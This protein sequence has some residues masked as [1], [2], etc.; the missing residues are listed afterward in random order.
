MQ[1]RTISKKDVYSPNLNYKNSFKKIKEFEDYIKKDDKFIRTFFIKSLTG[2]YVKTNLD[3]ELRLVGG[4][5]KTSVSFWILSEKKATDMVSMSE[6]GNQLVLSDGEDEKF[7]SAKRQTKAELEVEKSN[8][9]LRKIHEG[10]TH[11]V[12]IEYLV[13]TYADSLEELEDLSSIIEA[14]ADTY[15]LFL[16]TGIWQQKDMLLASVGLRK[17]MKRNIIDRPFNIEVL[18]SLLPNSSI[19]NFSKNGLYVGTHL[20]Y[21]THVSAN[22]LYGVSDT[23]TKNR[24]IFIYGESGAGKTYSIKVI[25]DQFLISNIKCIYVDPKPSPDYID[26]VKARKGKVYFVSDIKLNI[27]KEVQQLQDKKEDLSLSEHKLVIDNLCKL[28]SQITEVDQDEILESISL[29]YE[30]GKRIDFK[31]L[32]ENLKNEKTKTKFIGFISNIGVFKN[33]FD[34]DEENIDLNYPLICF[35]ISNSNASLTKKLMI[36]L[37]DYLKKNIFKDTNEPVQLIIDEAHMLTDTTIIGTL[38]SMARSANGGITAISQKRNAL[39]VMNDE[40]GQP[41]GRQNFAISL[42][43]NEKKEY[44][45]R[46]NYSTW[47]DDD[48]MRL[49]KLKKGEFF[50]ETSSGELYPCKYPLFRHS[51]VLESEF[52]KKRENEPPNELI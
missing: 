38:S 20:D 48:F 31:N 39:D 49:Q 42:C 4:K 6:Y 43:F 34:C 50:L 45:V 28:I 52:K 47:S 33:V 30:A 23:D 5:I 18:Y 25:G 21:N 24:N 26:Y 15:N 11:L 2:N 16:D 27:F 13:T 1:L 37:C 46:S 17:G 51:L 29:V 8:A 9:L 35:N 40:A 12:D 44:I 32:V 19:A 10:K 22:I 7:L 41:V 3:A 36:I 14:K